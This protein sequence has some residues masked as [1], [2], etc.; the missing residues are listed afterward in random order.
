MVA[1]LD[2]HSHTYSI[3][4]IAICNVTTIGVIGDATPNGWSGSTALVATAD[5]MLVWE[6]DI[7][8]AAAGEWKF[9]ANNDWAVNLGGSLDNLGQDGGNLATPGAGKKHVRLDLSTI[10]YTCTVK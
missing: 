1:N 2:A 3:S 4:Y 9:R 10:P 6:G 7:E 5:T 8:F